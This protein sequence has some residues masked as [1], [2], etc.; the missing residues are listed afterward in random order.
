MELEYL[1]SKVKGIM[2]VE[3]V[4]VLH[5]DHCHYEDLLV[6]DLDHLAVC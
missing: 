6:L 4:E 1:N 3:M 2:K 5:S